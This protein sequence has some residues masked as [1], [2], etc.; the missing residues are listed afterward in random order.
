M[1][2]TAAWLDPQT[3]S[4]KLQD[5]EY[6]INMHENEGLNNSSSID[7]PVV[8]SDAA[9]EPNEHVIPYNDLDNHDAREDL[10][11][12]DTNTPVHTGVTTRSG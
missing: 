7:L 5:G 8:P 1:R 11:N 12:D 9:A 10:N 2:E 3:E 6:Q 4:L